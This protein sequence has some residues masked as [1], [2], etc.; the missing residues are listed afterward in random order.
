MDRWPSLW[1]Q[2]CGLPPHPDVP[3]SQWFL[4]GIGGVLDE[5]S[6]SCWARG[7][8][9]LLGELRGQRPFQRSGLPCVQ[10]SRCGLRHGSPYFS[11]LILPV[12]AVNCHS[13]RRTTERVRD[14]LAKGL[15][16]LGR[17]SLRMARSLWLREMMCTRWMRSF[18]RE[19]SL[20][21]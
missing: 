10:S 14:I 3:G 17:W 16:F 9:L 1:S 7:E 21:W 5:F 13:A 15:C 6:V 2:V 8:S 12:T 18:P 11:V 19:S 20:D 4:L